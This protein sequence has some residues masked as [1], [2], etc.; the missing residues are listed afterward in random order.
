MNMDAPVHGPNKYA[1]LGLDATSKLFDALFE[2]CPLISFL[3]TGAVKNK[4]CSVHLQ[5]RCLSACVA[6]VGDCGLGAT[7]W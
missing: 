2:A 4:T 1:Q 7:G 5:G 6:R 3:A